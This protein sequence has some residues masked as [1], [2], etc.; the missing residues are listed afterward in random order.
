MRSL[1]QLAAVTTAIPFCYAAVPPIFDV[2]TVNDVLL[3]FDPNLEI[4][5]LTSPFG[6]C[7]DDQVKIIQ[8]TWVDV[9][10]NV[11]PPTI[12]ALLQPPGT[13]SQIDNIFNAL[14]RQSAS[15]TTVKGMVCVVQAWHVLISRTY[16]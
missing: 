15:R 11:L 13:F 4:V 2:D 10:T 12:S 3:A 8:Q 14:Y 9:M 1:F 7:T 6:G 5:P 16:S